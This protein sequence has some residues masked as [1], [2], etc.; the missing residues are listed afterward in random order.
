[1]GGRIR[2][3]GITTFSGG[4]A[5]PA[6]FLINYGSSYYRVRISNS[7]DSV[8]D[9]TAEHA[10]DIPIDTVYDSE[11]KEE[12]ELVSQGIHYEPSTD[13]LYL[14]FSSPI[15]AKVG[16]VYAYKNIKNAVG[17][18]AS[19]GS[20]SIVRNYG[21]RSFEL[22]ALAFRPNS[23]DKR[24]WFSTFEGDFVAAGIYTDPKE[25]RYME[26]NIS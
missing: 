16:M 20:M 4:G 25:I 22:E 19:A 7:L 8:A 5:N 3:A 13:R 18:P 24:L 23:T 14:A 2:V 12:K 10:F 15:S 1:M 21:D 6:V 26:G 9:I 17:T 11:E